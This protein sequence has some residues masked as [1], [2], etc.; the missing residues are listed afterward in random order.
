MSKEGSATLLLACLLS[1]LGIVAY[2]LESNQPKESTTLEVSAPK[3]SVKENLCPP[4]IRV[5]N[6]TQE[7][8]TKGG[9]EM[10]SILFSFCFW[11]IVGVGFRFL[12]QFLEPIVRRTENRL[13]DAVFYKLRIVVMIGVTLTI[14]FKGLAVIGAFVNFPGWL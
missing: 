11:I 6:G 4:P 10:L 2:H 1:T 14:F 12:F 13:D 7:E 5:Y 9:F 3:E 8:E